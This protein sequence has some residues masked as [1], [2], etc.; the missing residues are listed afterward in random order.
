[1]KE[2]LKHEEGPSMGAAMLAA[3]GLGWF[4]SVAD[5]VETFIK[6]EE[7]FKPNAE[8]HK[9]YEQFHNVYQR[10]Y[11]QTKELTK[12]LLANTVKYQLGQFLCESFILITL[13]AKPRLYIEIY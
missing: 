13:N 3:Y 8:N 9:R 4:E 7:V 11:K 6:V 5:C 2:K 10:V 12:E 1:M